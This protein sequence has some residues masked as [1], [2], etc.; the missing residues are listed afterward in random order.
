MTAL[1]H[2]LALVGPTGSGKAALGL[3][4]AERFALPILVC[5]S[6]KVYRRL[7][8]GSAKPDAEARARAQH[9]LIDLVDP[10]G[11]FTARQY[12]AEAWRHIGARGLFVGGT[13]FYLRAALWRA[14]GEGD[15]ATPTF[16]GQ[17]RD[18]F[19]AKWSEAERARPGATHQALAELDPETSAQ[20]HPNNWVR[21]V[22]ALGLCVAAGGPI[23]AIRAAD[24]PRPRART[25]FVWLDPGEGL[26][27][28]QVR[29]VDRMLARGWLA[30]VESLLAAGYDE[31][32]KSMR[33]LGY[34]QLVD[35]VRG[36]CGLEAAREA[37]LKATWQYARRQRTY[38]RHQL[39]AEDVVHIPE[40]GA[41]PWD[42]VRAF[43]DSP[44]QQARPNP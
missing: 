15:A 36:R 11:Q 28:R 5:D 13:G 44:S 37:I 21:V 31:H 7:D 27:D 4:V 12:A 6:V 32:H 14:T 40:P 43:L 22:R 42:R 8:I 1:P 34:K 29:R 33:S 26:R 9:H 23:S 3:E 38:F 10:D 30:E 19:E 24:P 39:P 16:E 17:E 18:A 35:V 2:V 25:L 20:I 41:M